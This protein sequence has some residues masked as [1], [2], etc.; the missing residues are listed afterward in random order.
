[1]TAT[2]YGQLDDVGWAF[3]DWLGLGAGVLLP[4]SL[5]SRYE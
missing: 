2:L 4:L 3:T 1:M 5:R